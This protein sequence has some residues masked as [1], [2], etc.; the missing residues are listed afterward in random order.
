MDSNKYASSA[1]NIDEHTHGNAIRDAHGDADADSYANEYG[2]TSADMDADS[3]AGFNLD[4]DSIASANLHADPI[5]Y[6]D[7]GA[8][9]HAGSCC[10]DSSGKLF[11]NCIDV[12]IQ[13][14]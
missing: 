7:I 13:D 5:A 9:I 8:Q 6:A 11:S 1:A 3:V 10:R 12:Q 4:S 2:N 14:S